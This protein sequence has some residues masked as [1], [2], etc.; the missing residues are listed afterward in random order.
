MSSSPTLFCGDI[1]GTHTRLRLVTLC[2]SEPTGF[3]T[4]R[5]DRFPSAEIRDLETA[6]EQFLAEAAPPAIDAA[7]FAVAGPI[8]SSGGET[9]A[10]LTNLPWKLSSQILSAR[11]NIPRVALVNDFV[12]IGHSIDPLPPEALLPLSSGEAMPQAT[13]LVIGPGTGLGVC[14]RFWS[15]EGYHVLA[16]EGGHIPFG[17]RD[18]EEIALLRWLRRDYPRVSNERLLSGPGIVALYRFYLQRSGGIE[19]E[20]PCLSSSDPAAAI[21]Q[22]ALAGQSAIAAAT[23]DR[24]CSLLGS[25]AGDLALV[26]LPRGGIFLAGGIPPHIADWL[27]RSEF[28]TAFRAK[29]RLAPVME[30]LPIYLVQRRDVGLLGAARLAHIQ[31]TN[32]TC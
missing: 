9:T 30:H 21:S 25:V 16:S 12:A 32:P 23:L 18:E 3:Q 14:H 2:A 15:P 26:T 27:M 19:A 31:L 6:A 11:L 8:E 1:G 5:E 24:F 20:D 28:L 10:R 13:Q 4:L 17:P 7:C 22:A 29:G